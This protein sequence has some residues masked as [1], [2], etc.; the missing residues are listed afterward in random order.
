VRS[1]RTRWFILGGLVVTLALAFGASR[2]ASSKPDG[3][4]KVAADEG[5]D[6]NEKPHALN[7]S[8]FAD[9]ETRGIGDPGLG[10]GVAG[11][12]GVV[13]TFGIAGGVVWG[14]AHRRRTGRAVTTAE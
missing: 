2:Y 14:V 6:S 4:E 13:I 8:P 3:L 1:G 5:L 9:Y 10:T 12:V 7:D 11:G